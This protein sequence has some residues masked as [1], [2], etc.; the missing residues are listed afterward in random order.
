MDLGIVDMW[1]VSL[2]RTGSCIDLCATSPNGVN[3]GWY[4]ACVGMN[5]I[6]V[7]EQRVLANGNYDPRPE[8]CRPNMQVII[9]ALPDE[10]AKVF[11][12][13]Y[14]IEAS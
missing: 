13:A 14:K 4:R 1:D 5:G 7:L 3:N 10:Y 2:T 12:R 9:D 11:R 6:L 8:S